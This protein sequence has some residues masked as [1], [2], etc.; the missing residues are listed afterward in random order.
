MKKPKKTK[1]PKPKPKKKKKTVDLSNPVL[2]RIRAEKG[3]AT[4]IAAELGI[5]PAT[6]DPYKRTTVW[7]WT[8]VPAEH[9]IKVSEFL[10]IARHR[11][12]PDIYPDR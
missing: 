5:N 11:I 2:A 9:V 6:G 4:K 8:R 12:R 1:K 3:L 7:M 10:R